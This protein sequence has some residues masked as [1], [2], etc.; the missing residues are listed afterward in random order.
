MWSWLLSITGI[1]GMY[2]AG[3]RLAVGWLVGLLSE[4]LWLIYAIVTKQWGF[5]LGVAAY[6]YVFYANW[7]A[8]SKTSEEE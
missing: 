4:A 1:L 8:W 6:S 2:L 3:K 7:R 5:L